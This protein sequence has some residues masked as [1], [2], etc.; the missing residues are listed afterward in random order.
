M[1]VPGNRDTVIRHGRIVFL[2][3]V[4][5]HLGMLR[6]RNTI[7]F[8]SDKAA[9]ETHCAGTCFDLAAMVGLVTDAIQVHHDLRR[10]NAPVIQLP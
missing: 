8:A 3:E 6:A 7:A 4:R 5:R 10:D 2:D 9:I 1:P